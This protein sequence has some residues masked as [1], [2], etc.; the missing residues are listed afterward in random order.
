MRGLMF[1]DV[2]KETKME[3]KESCEIPPLK[4]YSIERAN[5]VLYD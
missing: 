5:E 1:D 2:T 3:W 4:F